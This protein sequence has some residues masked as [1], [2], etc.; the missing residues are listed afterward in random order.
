[1]IYYLHLNYYSRILSIMIAIT[2]SINYIDNSK[3]IMKIVYFTL[4]FKIKIAIAIM[5]IIYLKT[6][7]VN[8]IAKMKYY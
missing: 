5:K 1:M 7:K 6:I 4:D 8:N 2:T 3:V